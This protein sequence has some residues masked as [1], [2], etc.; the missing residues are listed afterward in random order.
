MTPSGA[1]LIQSKAKMTHSPDRADAFVM[2]CWGRLQQSRGERN[3]LMLERS[4]VG[5][6]RSGGMREPA[7]LVLGGPTTEERWSSVTRERI[8]DSDLPVFW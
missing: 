2:A 6:A 8:V 4:E 1:V 5:R 7:E 3:R